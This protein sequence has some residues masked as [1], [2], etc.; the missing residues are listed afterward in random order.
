MRKFDTKNN[1]LGYDLGAGVNGYFSRHVGIRGD[2][3][4]FH[5]LQDLD[6]GARRDRGSDIRRR[7]SWTSGGPASACRCD[8]SR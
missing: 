4:R 2:V 7:R 6:T 3:R 1:S 5:A 8:S